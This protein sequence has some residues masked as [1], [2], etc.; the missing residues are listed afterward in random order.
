MLDLSHFRGPELV[1]IFNVLTNSAVT[2]FESQEAG[3][4]R[5]E[6]FLRE[7][8]WS[9][10]QLA[11]AIERAVPG[12]KV[13][14]FVPPVVETVVMGGPEMNVAQPAAPAEPEAPAVAAEP[15][16][17]GGDDEGEKAASQPT[18]VALELDDTDRRILATLSV[19]G[20]CKVGVMRTRWIAEDGAFAKLAPTQQKGMMRRSVRRLE[21]AGKIKKDGMIFSLPAA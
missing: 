8:G 2:R 19:I 21:A 14:E 9:E 15:V 1:G 3:I 16:G 18:A 4:R 17:A 7:R 10:E 5:I 6:R 20:P 11:D 13:S 12:R